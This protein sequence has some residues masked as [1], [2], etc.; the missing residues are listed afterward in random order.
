M[1]EP[2]P[3]SPRRLSSKG[4]SFLVG[5]FGPWMCVSQRKNCGTPRILG[6]EFSSSIHVRIKKELY[7][8]SRPVMYL[9]PHR[10]YRKFVPGPQQ[11]ISVVHLIEQIKRQSR[12]SPVE[13]LDDV[14]SLIGLATYELMLVPAC[15]AIAAATGA[16]HPQSSTAQRH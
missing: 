7:Q 1:R 13:M 3:I 4:R 9:Y 11:Q 14:C 6:C 12:P 8:D 16:L 15:S 10:F 5:T 2:T